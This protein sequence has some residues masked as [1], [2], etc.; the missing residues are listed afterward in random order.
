MRVPTDKACQCCV[1]CTQFAVV[2]HRVEWLDQA[3]IQRSS[4]KPIGTLYHTT[5]Q[6][7]SFMLIRVFHGAYS[8][9][10]IHLNL[11]F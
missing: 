4:H 9:W 7:N 2:L 3:V 11:L 10:K 5:Y 8:I 1:Y 6:W